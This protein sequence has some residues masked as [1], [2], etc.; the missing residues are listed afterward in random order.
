MK[1]KE[2]LLVLLVLTA[3]I[4]AS[5][6]GNPWDC[7]GEDFLREYGNEGSAYAYYITFN[8]EPYFVFE[9]KDE[10]YVSVDLKNCNLVTDEALSGQL[11]SSYLLLKTGE[12]SDYKNAYGKITACHQFISHVGKVNRLLGAIDKIIATFTGPIAE[13]LERRIP[14]LA[15]K[16]APKGWSIEFQ[17]GSKFIMG[18]MVQGSKKLAGQVVVLELTTYATGAMADSI[19]GKIYDYSVLSDG[20]AT[21]SMNGYFYTNSIVVLA[22]VNDDLAYYLGPE[23]E[24]SELVDEVNKLIQM[25]LSFAGVIQPECGNLEAEVLPVLLQASGRYKQVLAQGQENTPDY[26]IWVSG[27]SQ[28][29]GESLLIADS[30]INQLGFLFDL[31][32]LLKGLV[33][34]YDTDAVL[35]KSEFARQLHGESHY[36]YDRG[37]FISSRDRA[38]KSH[39]LKLDTLE[40]ESSM[41]F[42]RF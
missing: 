12:L 3:T 40:F 16:I 26:I 19:F 32:L 35:K 2:L 41:V 34:G 13:E 39:Q 30:N 37:L 29:A 15:A 4:P 20:L 6:S 36:Y 42:R 24:G 9:S 31:K 27:L 1:S 18:G 17:R 23:V 28:K 7:N 22:T 21:R 11:V 33:Y 10:I 5:T 38:E 25:A 8:D 14:G